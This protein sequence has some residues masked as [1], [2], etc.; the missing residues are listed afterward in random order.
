MTID[1]PIVAVCEK[2]FVPLR[3]SSVFACLSH[4]SAGR[5]EYRFA[6]KK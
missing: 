3:I 4:L 5:F 1:M 2:D 6:L